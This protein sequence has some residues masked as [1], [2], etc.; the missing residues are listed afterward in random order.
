[1]I[2]AGAIYNRAVACSVAAL[3][4]FAGGGRAWACASCGC[5]D[6][7]LTASG[8]ERPYRNRIR[9][10][11]DER[12]GSFTQGD[13]VSGQSV[14]TL[15]TTIGASWSP[16]KR[17]TIAAQLPWVTSW[18][19]PSAG[20]RTLVNGLGDLELS[21]RGVVFQERGFA[22]HHVLWLS[23]GL[24]FPTGYRAY[25]GTGY[26]IPDDDQPGSGSY[27]PFAGVTYGWFSERLWSVFSSLSGRWTTRGWHGYRRG[28][29]LSSTTAVQ[30]QPWSWGAAQ[31]GVDWTLQAADTLDNGAA[32]PDTG[33]F[34]GYAMAGVLFNP[35]R[36]LL[37]RA[38]VDVPAITRLEGRQSR[39]VQA[40]VQVAYD[41]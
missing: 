29:F 10:V 38:A 15:R 34:A 2:A 30:F 13:P 32:V 11:L 25:D 6:E 17:I 26:P 41:F 8:V 31:L 40:F 1:M 4:L 3:L 39:G 7:T 5:G 14:D 22:P 24:K 37:L 23:G 35:W 9:V 28:E 36:D 12:Y 18:V 19:T 33:G 21:V 27:D 20:T 16:H